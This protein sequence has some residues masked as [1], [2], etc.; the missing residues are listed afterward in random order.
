MEIMKLKIKIYEIKNSLEDVNN[1]F[2]KVDFLKSLQTWISINKIVKSKEQWEKW[3][4]KK[5][6]KYW[7][8]WDII[9]HS[10]IHKIGTPFKISSKLLWSF[11]VLQ[12]VISSHRQIILPA[13]SL[14]QVTF[15][16]FLNMSMK[17][18]LTYTKWE[19]IE[20][21]FK[22]IMPENIPNMM[23]SIYPNFSTNS[24]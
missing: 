7:N 2:E 4:K 1:S 17:C 24:K 18:L 9:K 14:M 15:S 3:M 23:K 11:S 21:Y 20:Q 10:N 5:E 16:H 22:K 19:C 6:Q 12:P 8:L 13:F